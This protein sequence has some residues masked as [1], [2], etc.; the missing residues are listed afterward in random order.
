[1]VILCETSGFAANV[2]FCSISDP[3]WRG[4]AT[5]SKT[6]F[7]QA[8]VSEGS[9]TRAP[10]TELAPMVSQ[11]RCGNRLPQRTGSQGVTWKAELGEKPKKDRGRPLRG[12]SHPG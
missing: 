4:A 5:S 7:G 6:S 10:Q 12:P 1:D 9:P 2:D 8:F 11:K 3:A